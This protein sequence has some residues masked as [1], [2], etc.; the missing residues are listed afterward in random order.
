M[1]TAIAYLLEMPIVSSHGTG[2]TG[3]YACCKAV[4]KAGGTMEIGSVRSP[5]GLSDGTSGTTVT[6][7]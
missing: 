7:T 6:I 2:G 4:E 5:S 1:S 3:I